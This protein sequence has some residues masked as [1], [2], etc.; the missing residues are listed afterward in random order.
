MMT[1]THAKK[2]KYRVQGVS[3]GSGEKGAWFS[4]LG[5]L[6]SEE[7]HLNHREGEIKGSLFQALE[8]AFAKR[9]WDLGVVPS[10]A[11]MKRGT[12]KME[13][14]QAGKVDRS[15]PIHPLTGHVS[16]LGT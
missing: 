8:M 6:S 4:M 13:W 1:N 11:G 5:Q 9:S 15:M 16:H 2:E 14:D 12:G 7:W 10:T 3:D